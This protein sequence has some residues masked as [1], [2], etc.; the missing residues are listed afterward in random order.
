MKVSTQILPRG[1]MCVF[2]GT[3]T[4]LLFATT[5]CERHTARDTPIASQAV[6]A[7]PALTST[8]SQLVRHHTRTVVASWYDVPPDSVAARRAAPE[9]LTAA[10]DKLPLGTRVR[11][12]NIGNG[13]SVI[14]RIT[15]RGVPRGKPPLDLCRQAAERLEMVRE[16]TTKVE[17]EI[18]PDEETPGAAADASA[19]AR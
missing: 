11:V 10:H 9:E 3:L 6:E 15:D 5:S 4:L 13:K 1:T 17:M 19:A 18:V 8:P 12:T 7:S 16:G 14:V 2:A